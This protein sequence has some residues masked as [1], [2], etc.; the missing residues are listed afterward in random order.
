MKNIITSF[1]GLMLLVACQS[2]QPEARK[3]VSYSS[4]SFLNESVAKN[5][6]ILQQEEEHIFKIINADSTRIFTNSP[7]GFWY[8]FLEKKETKDTVFPQ[9]GDLVIFSYN[10]INLKGDTIYS[11]EELGTRE[12]YVDEERI[13]SGLAQGLKL[14]QEGESAHFLFPSYKAFGFYGDLQKIGSNVPLQSIVTLQKINK[15]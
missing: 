1:L 12:Y 11:T 13:F 4:G 9:K 6:I 5:K 15:N 14:M 8:S 10:L 2:K 3:P 7:D